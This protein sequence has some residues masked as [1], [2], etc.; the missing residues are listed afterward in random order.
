MRRNDA[1]VSRFAGAEDSFGRADAPFFCLWI[2]WG[3]CK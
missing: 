1:L 3:G 2:D